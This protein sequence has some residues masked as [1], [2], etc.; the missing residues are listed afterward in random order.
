MPV[1]QK[2][3]PDADIADVVQSVKSL[4]AQFAQ[5]PAPVTGLLR[6]VRAR[7]T[8]VHPRRQVCGSSG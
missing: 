5:P 2:I 6:G 7:Y 1:W 8:R 3:P 4:S